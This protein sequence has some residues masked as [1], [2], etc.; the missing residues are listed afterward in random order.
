M[1]ENISFEDV[2][3]AAVAFAIFIIAPVIVALLFNELNLAVAAVIMATF[4][5]VECFI[6]LVVYIYNILRRFLK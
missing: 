1:K 5:A 2:I 3:M 6:L 4:A